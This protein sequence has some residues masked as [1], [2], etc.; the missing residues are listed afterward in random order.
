MA[1]TGWFTDPTGRHRV[2]YRDPQWTVWV[3]DAG[4]AER[5]PGDLSRI[6]R[7]RRRNRIIA[8][9]AAC[10]AVLLGI[11]V[12]TAM[13]RSAR[14][15]QRYY[16]A[17]PAEFKREMDH[18][19]LPPSVTRSSKPD[20]ELVMDGTDAEV[21]RYFVAQPGFT[22]AQALDD[23]VVALKTQGYRFIRLGRS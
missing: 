6:R 2:R 20:D 14:Q 21:T 8:I 3:A 11:I 7:S 10:L 9:V 12:V 16:E 19:V 18:W 17:A 1:K 13:N 22:T 4:D 5:D 23:L 15:Q